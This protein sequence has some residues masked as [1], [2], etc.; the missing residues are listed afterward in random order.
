[1]SLEP[2]VHLICNTAKCPQLA[3]EKLESVLKSPGKVLEF[4]SYKPVVAV[5]LMMML[6]TTVAS[7][8]LLCIVVTDAI[9]DIDVDDVGCR[10]RHFHQPFLFSNLRLTG[11]CGSVKSN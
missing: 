7:I 10:L 2:F 8:Y 4:V 1:M 9:I 3:F 6:T 11:D 5:L